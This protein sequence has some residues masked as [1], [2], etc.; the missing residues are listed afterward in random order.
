MNS[1]I[2]HMYDASYTVST[3]VFDFSNCST[4]HSPN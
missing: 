1:K 4:W 2:T 3:P